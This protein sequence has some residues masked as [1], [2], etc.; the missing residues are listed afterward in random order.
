MRDLAE[1][2]EMNGP[3]RAELQAERIAN[4][5][6]AR[7]LNGDWRA[8]FEKSEADRARR[9]AAIKR[10]HTRR[11]CILVINAVIDE[12]EV[13][14][15]CQRTARSIRLRPARKRLMAGISVRESATP[16]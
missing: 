5:E 6:R 12:I 3:R 8:R 9:H 7:L 10:E 13:E 14:I 2:R 16:H 1:I 11:I 4:A 15:F